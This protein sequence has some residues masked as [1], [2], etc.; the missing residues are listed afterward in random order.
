[1]G[2]ANRRTHWSTVDDI[3]IDLSILKELMVDD[4]REAGRLPSDDGTAHYG[5][6]AYDA[7]L[8][9]VPHNAYLAS[10]SRPRI[11]LQRIWQVSAKRLE[12]WDMLPALQEVRHPAR[13]LHSDE[14]WSTP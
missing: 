9:E 14:T 8:R 3:E 7:Y 2:H 12:D 1:M 6:G 11:H 10:S 4:H 13:L 5:R